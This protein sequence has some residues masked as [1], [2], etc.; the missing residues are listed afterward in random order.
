MNEFDLKIMAIRMFNELTQE[1]WGAKLTT[2]EFDYLWDM[3]LEHL[4][5]ELL[6][7]FDVLIMKRGL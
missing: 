3:D 2:T 7:L 5:E 1:I 6:M 4:H